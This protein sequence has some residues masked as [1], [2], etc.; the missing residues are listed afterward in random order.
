MALP[1]LMHIAPRLTRPG[2]RSVN[3]WPRK[4]IV[5]L[6]CLCRGALKAFCTALG[7][8]RAFRG[9]GRN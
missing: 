7:F 5:R 4:M 8:L 2:K 6:L 9:E 1:P 3:L